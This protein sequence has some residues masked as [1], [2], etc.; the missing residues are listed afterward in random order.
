M[1]LRRGF[2]RARRRPRTL[3]RRTT[4]RRKD[5]PRRLRRRVLPRLSR[6]SR[7]RAQ[8]VPFLSRAS[9]RRVGFIPRPLSNP[10]H[11]RPHRLLSPLPHRPSHVS[12][13]RR[14][15]TSPSR[16]LARPTKRQARARDG[17]QDG[18]HH[19]CV[20][21]IIVVVR[22]VRRLR[23]RRVRRRVR[24]VVPRRLRHAL[25]RPSLA[26]ARASTSMEGCMHSRIGME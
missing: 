25:D 15:S 3:C 24:R 1:N 16:A 2:R 22:R 12:R 19:R 7:A 13:R 4:R 14:P 18:S 26:F 23:R 10:S 5:P 21:G 8:D 17:V 20:V 9:A 11:A 6:P